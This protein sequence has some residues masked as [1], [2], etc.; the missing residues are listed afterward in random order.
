MSTLVILGGTTDGLKAAVSARAQGHQVR[1]FTAYPY[2]GEDVTARRRERTQEEEKRTQDITIRACSTPARLKRAFVSAMKE[3]GVSCA[4]LTRPVALCE[5]NGVVCGVLVADKQGMREIP[6]D[7]VLDATLY[8]EANALFAGKRLTFGQG[9]TLTLRAEYTNAACEPPLEGVRWLHGTLQEGH[10]QA[11]KTVPLPC[12][13]TLSQARAYAMSQTDALVRALAPLMGGAALYPAL[14]LSPDIDAPDVPTVDVH[15]FTRVGGTI[16]YAQDARVGDKRAFTNG[17]QL[18]YA[19]DALGRVRIDET[20]L[21]REQ[22]PL[23]VVGAG[24]AGVWAALEAVQNGVV[25]ALTDIYPAAGGTRV[26]GGVSGLYFGNR[27]ALFG[28]IW[29]QLHEHARALQTPFCAATEALYHHE[30]LRQAGIT[31]NGCCLPVQLTKK[32]RLIDTVLCAGEDHL[33]LYEPKQVLDATGDADIAVLAGCE[34]VT[35]DEETHFGINYSQWQICDTNNKP[36]SHID[37][38]V[39]NVDSR[40]EW[41]A[42][43]EKNLA[44]TKQYDLYD[45]LTVRESR[46]LCARVVVTLQDVVRGVDYPD[47]L[48][49]AYSTHD[50]HGRSMSVYGRLGLLPALGAPKF[51]Q[52]PRRALLPAKVDNLTVAGKAIGTTH[53]VFNYIRMCPDIITLG[54]IAGRLCARAVK[55]DS[56]PQDVDITDIQTD[57]RACGALLPAPAYDPRAVAVGVSCGDEASFAT[58]LMADDQAIYEYLCALDA[59]GC[60]SS[61]SLMDEALLWYGDMRGCARLTAL[62]KRLNDDAKQIV[63][64]DRQRETGVIKAGATIEDTPYW[65]INRLCVLLSRAKYGKASPVIIECM[66]STVSGGGWHNDSS[67]YAIG[68]IDCQSIPNYDRIFCMAYSALLMPN[69]RYAQPLSRL[70]DITKTG[71]PRGSDCYQRYLINQLDKAK[72]ACE[73]L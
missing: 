39:L 66:D 51:V 32:E 67:P 6:C 19:I 52:I 44:S 3:A 11:V 36:Y 30:K 17:Q 62:L 38:G 5:Q 21:T 56:L 69:A 23:L 47:A 43:L 70:I 15:G 65:R 18:T 10:L 35:G 54:I 46:R 2:L 71:A 7:A 31:M 1:L 50:P 24:T 48:C 72:N 20:F 4:Y 28:R 61:R 49:T 42:A 12:D 27:S 55:E 13:M 16:T 26:M 53:D 34:T 68:R 64:R 29:R 25:P 22:A 37:Q 63:Y 58:A 33:T 41:N 9:Q 14:P 8:G 57:M 59:D 60:V 73:A 40:E 45:M